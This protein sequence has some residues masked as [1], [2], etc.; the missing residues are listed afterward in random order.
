M[1]TILKNKKILISSE[2]DCFQLG[3]KIEKNKILCVLKVT[4]DN[5]AQGVQIS[6]R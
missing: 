3:E 6:V 1:E 5:Q 2:T 4:K